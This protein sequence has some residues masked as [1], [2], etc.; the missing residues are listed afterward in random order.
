MNASGKQALVLLPGLLCNARLFSDQAAALADLADR[1]T[2]LVVYTTDPNIT[3]NLIQTVLDSP[4]E[5]VKIL[6]ASLAPAF[7]ELSAPRE[8]CRA[9]A[10]HDG[11]VEQFARTIAASD[12]CRSSIAFGSM[13][14]MVFSIVGFA[15]VT[16]LAFMQNMGAV[17]WML[18]AGLQLV[19]CALVCLL[20][21]L[22]RL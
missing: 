17:S 18:I 20:P 4:S 12:S 10:A 22:R 19:C 6:P 11:T 16:F 7:E 8:E 21:N 14:Q 5:L 13:L 3:P 2:T 1:E 15:L 9:Y